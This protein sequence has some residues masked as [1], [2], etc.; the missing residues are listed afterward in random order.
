MRALGNV[1]KFTGLYGFYWHHLAPRFSL[2]V[3]PK[4]KGKVV[5][6]AWPSVAIV[7]KNGRAMYR[8]DGRPSA[9]RKFYAERA[10]AIAFAEEL[11]RL[12]GDGG[13]V[14][15]S[16]PAELRQDAIEAATILEPWGRS[17]AE[18]AKHY[19]AHLKAEKARAAAVTIE[20]AVKDYLDAKWQEHERG[21]LADLTMSELRLRMGIVQRAFAG[22]RI[23]D[24][25]QKAIQ[26]FLDG[27]PHSARTRLNIRIKL[28]QLLNHC[29]RRGWIA[30]N[31]AELTSVRVPARDVAA[32]SIAE[33]T[34]LLRAA[35]RCPTLLPHVAVALFAG[36]RPGELAALRWNDVHFATAQIEVRPETSKTRQRRFVPLDPLLAE[37]LLPQRRPSGKIMPPNF[38]KLWKALRSDAGLVK[39]SGK[40]GWADIL[41]HTHATFWLAIHGDRPRLA[42]HLGNSVDVIR[43]FYRKAVPLAEAEKFWQLR[44]TADADSNILTGHF[45]TAG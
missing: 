23:I 1:R 15:L 42:E 31:A 37:W 41:R 18:A 6:R 26:A 32:L 36:L 39:L 44:P 4:I 25:D 8:V 43:N 20:T 11:A 24:L 21:E 19:A 9:G 33:S 34:K 35:E 22:Q 7:A 2:V 5:R 10:E 12:K 38:Q 45:A 17:L 16:M 28:S 3:M 27:L 29:R 30:S 14:A 40:R 13:K